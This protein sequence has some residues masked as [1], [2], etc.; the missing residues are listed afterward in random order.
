MAQN[1]PAET[2]FQGQM[3]QAGK[4]LRRKR[5]QGGRA[6]NILAVGHKKTT[7]AYWATVVY[8]LTTSCLFR[9]IE[10]GRVNRL[11]DNRL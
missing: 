1:Y 6:P 7:A 8:D 2:V 10:N 3:R 11:V 9:H 5:R 4:M